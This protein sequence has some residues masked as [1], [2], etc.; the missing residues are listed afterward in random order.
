MGIKE[1]TKDLTTIFSPWG[2]YRFNHM[3]FRLRNTPAVFQSLMETVL[4]KCNSVASVYIDDVLIY[5]NSWSEHLVHVKLVLEA[6]KEAE[7]K[8]KPSKCQWSRHHL[9]YL[10][11]KVGCGEVAVPNRR[12]GKI[13]ANGYKTGVVGFSV[14]P[15]L[16]A[17]P[18]LVKSKKFIFN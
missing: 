7:L 10:G 13:S 12:Y 18:S 16:F 5:C 9:E 2:R 8:T 15:N 6:L 4:K 17:H 1:D 11:H 3:P 14:I